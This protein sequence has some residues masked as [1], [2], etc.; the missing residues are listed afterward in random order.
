MYQQ[1][2]L[3]SSGGNG[4][5]SDYVGG[6][7]VWGKRLGS[8]KKQ[9]RGELTN[10]GKWNLLIFHRY[11]KKKK[12]TSQFLFWKPLLF[13]KTKMHTKPFALQTMAQ[14]KCKLVRYVPDC[15][16]WHDSGFFQCPNSQAGEGSV[17]PPNR[18]PK[19]REVMWTAQANAWQN[20]APACE[21]SHRVCILLSQGLRCFVV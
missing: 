21:E 10:P 16:V 7:S 15:N 6:K 11:E 3:S 1:V 5:Q 17:H 9:S 13:R 14:T 12:R 19:L 4:V 2:L 8:K 18:T 20:L